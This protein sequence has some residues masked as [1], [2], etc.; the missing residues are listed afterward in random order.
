[1]NIGGNM[2]VAVSVV[3]FSKNEQLVKELIRNFPDSKI[4]SEGKRIQKNELA[5]YYKGAEAIIV[6]LEKIDDELLSLLPDLKIIAKYGVGLDNIDLEACNKRGIEVGWTAGVNKH[7]VAEMTLGFMLMLSR[8]LY[9]TSN[10][11]KTGLWNRSGGNSL[12]VKTIGIIGLGHIGKEVVRLLTPIGSKLLCN[13]ILDVSSFAL[14]NQIQ[15]VGKEEIYKS[16]DIIS[17]HTPLTELTRNMI[18]K[19][20]MILM[21][22]S[23]FIINSARGGIINE[24][25]LKWALKNQ[26]I[27]GAALDVYNEEPPIDHELLE[28]PNLIC[29]PHIG[30]NSYEA[31]VAMGMSAIEHLLKFQNSKGN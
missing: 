26:I 12:L 16:S 15:V 29:T 24:E 31:V 8:N 1:M 6:G 4:N 20:A 9:L 25:D 11:L 10:Q 19:E 17:V 13:D 3:A 21:K 28:M 27:A 5:E 30:G 7:A 18:N 22:S 2:K 23:T 14:E